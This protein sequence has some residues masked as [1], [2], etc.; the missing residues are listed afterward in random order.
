MRKSVLRGSG[1]TP[2]EVYLANLAD[3]TFLNLWAY[4]N[5][6]VRRVVNG[7]RASRELCDLL[8]VCG[9]NLIIFSDKTCEWPQTQNTAIAWTRWYRKA[10]QKSVD[11]I[12]GALRQIRTDAENIFVDPECT[13][14]IPLALPAPECARY[15]GIVVA[16][17]AYKACS[18]YF[19]GDAGSFMIYPE[20]KGSDHS[21]PEVGGTHPFAIGDVNPGGNFIHVVNE[22]TLDV[23]MRELDT[24]AD[25]T[26]YLQKKETFIRS[27]RLTTST[28]EEELVA[29][30]VTHVGADGEHDF[31]HPQGRPWRDDDHLALGQGHFAALLQNPQYLQKQEEDRV[32][33]VWDRLITTFTDNMLAGTTTG[34]EGENYDLKQHEIG[35]RYMA[36]EPRTRRRTLGHA[37]MGVLERSNQVPR[38]MRAVT[39]GP[40]DKDRDSGFV[41]MTLAHPEFELEGGYQQYRQA[42][43]NMLRAYC[44][45]IGSKCRHLKRIIGIATEPPARES[46]QKASSE[47]LLVFHPVEWTSELESETE[48]LC[49]H[50]EILQEGNFSTSAFHVQE[51]PDEPDSQTDASLQAPGLNRRE[52]RTLRARDR[53]NV[54]R[55]AR[56]RRP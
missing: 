29:Y 10:I 27:G 3:R 38:A 22:L 55:G 42:R 7:H 34:P 12:N 54:K 39:P 16:N 19:G 50:F 26:A 1:T 35:V 52:R 17:G 53:R 8:V 32:S 25:F 48:D 36:L 40:N 21:N 24:V 23:L 44:Q 6:Y 46:N 41:F 2:P 5:T 43:T 47:D 51:Y 4:P 37:I 31:V 56:Q 15:H 11:Q 49:K 9:D 14:S 18:E 45:G 13:Q 33:Y 20:L 28:G 30:Y